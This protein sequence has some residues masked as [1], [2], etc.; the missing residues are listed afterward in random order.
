MQKG[1]VGYLSEMNDIQ[2][3]DALRA[4]DYSMNKLDNGYNDTIQKI[5]NMAA[6]RIKDAKASG[7]LSTMADISTFRNELASTFDEI[8]KTSLVFAEEKSRV[9][10]YYKTVGDKLLAQNKLDN[11]VDEVAS[12][13]LGYLVNKNGRQY[14][15][16]KTPYVDYALKKAMI[17]QDSQNEFNANQADLDRQIKLQQ[18]G[19][20]LP[21]GSA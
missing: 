8:A 7:K 6:S 4:Y 12:Q 20:I 10:E 17:L 19:G 1:I 2:S 9:S 15:A 5:S 14:G 13:Q 18:S 21:T 11:E 3:Q 16:T